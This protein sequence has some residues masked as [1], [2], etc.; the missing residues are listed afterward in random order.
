MMRTSWRG[1]GVGSS[2]FHGVF[3][4]SR[5]AVVVLG[6][7]L[8]LRSTRRW[9]DNLNCFSPGIWRLGRDYF[10][11]CRLL[12]GNNLDYFNWISHLVRFQF[13]SWRVLVLFWG[14]L[15]RVGGWWLLVVLG[16]I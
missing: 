8:F 4:A 16:Y 15:F 2:F 13:W 11:R 10:D 12:I 14:Y 1:R 6:S 7:L 3:A 9:R 5:R